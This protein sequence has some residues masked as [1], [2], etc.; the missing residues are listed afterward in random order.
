MSIGVG[1]IGSG[2]IGKVH[3]LAYRAAPAVFGLEPPRL[4]I[5]AD[6]DDAT[7][8]RRGAG[9]RVS[10]LDRRLADPRR[11]S[12]GGSGRHHR[13]NHLHEEMALA[14][15]AAGKA[16]Y[17]E[18]PLAP[19]ADG[20]GRMVAAA[21]AA[22][23]RTMVGFN[24]LKNPI[25]AVA[26]EIIESGE[27]GDVF[28]YRGW[29]FE[30]YMHDPDTLVNAWRLNP[31]TGDGVTSD[32]GSHAIS[33][34]RYLVGDIAEVS[35]RRTTVKRTRAVGEDGQEVEVAFPI[36]WLP[37]FGLA[38]APAG[39]SRRPGWR[40]GTNTPS[41]SKSSARRGRWRSTS[42]DSA[43]SGS[44]RQASPEAAKGSPPSSPGRPIPTSPR[45]FP[46]RVTNSAST[47]SR[48]S[49]FG[50]SWLGS[51]R[52]ARHRGPTSG[53]PGRSR[54]WSTPSSRQTDPDTGPQSAD[55]NPFLSCVCAWLGYQKPR[56][57][58]ARTG[59]DTRPCSCVVGVR[60]P[61]LTTQNGFSPP[62]IRGGGQRCRLRP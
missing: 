48:R 35:A 49:R 55:P 34:A 22:G 44:T 11:G 26:R 1:L 42:S 7:A 15:I 59:L 61:R 30:D 25:A 50:T 19:T 12:R 36:P 13:P 60:K 51:I 53:K 32:L 27:I 62:G 54:R 14:A 56:L 23:V 45:L 31:E 20:A 52:H 10:S 17:C 24:Y 5:L 16:V 3:A 47:I 57:R 39:R 28:G 29:H 4:E 2:F 43:N 37:W 6:I 46:R 8:A 33:M 9:P 58:H 40:P 21:E 41:R 18:K 38:M